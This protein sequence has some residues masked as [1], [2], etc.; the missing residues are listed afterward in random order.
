MGL[1][2]GA[3]LGGITILFKNTKTYLI[4]G[5]LIKWKEFQSVVP[6]KVVR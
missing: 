4:N 2:L 1:P 5:D 3:A 6:E